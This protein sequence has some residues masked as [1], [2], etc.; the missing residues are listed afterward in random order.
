MQTEAEPGMLRIVTGK[1]CFPVAQWA[2]VLQE[3][4]SNAKDIY[5][6]R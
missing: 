4:G 6:R 1:V 2:Q 5:G 3:M